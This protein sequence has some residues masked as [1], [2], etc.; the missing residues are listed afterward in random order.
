MKLINLIRCFLG[1]AL[2]VHHQNNTQL[3]NE[4]DYKS[5]IEDF[6]QA[7]VVKYILPALKKNDPRAGASKFIK[8]GF[9]KKIQ[10][11]ILDLKNKDSIF[12]P[13]ECLSKHYASQYVCGK[14]SQ[15]NNVITI[16]IDDR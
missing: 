2:S 12:V 7:E 4:L 16:M 8:T 9:Y 15:E 5:K 11:C 3:D 1:R 14:T 10:I 13:F 6:L